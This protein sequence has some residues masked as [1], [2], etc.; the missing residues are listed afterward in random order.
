MKNRIAI[1]LFIPLYFGCT[2]TIEPFPK[3]PVP[4]V[5]VA[6]MFINSSLE[7]KKIMKPFKTI[8]HMLQ[9]T[10]TDGEEAKILALIMDCKTDTTLNQLVNKLY[11]TGL[12]TN[13]T[14]RWDEERNS[15]RSPGLFDQL[16]SKVSSEELSQTP[17]NKTFGNGFF[18]AVFSDKTLNTQSARKMLSAISMHI[19]GK[20]YEGSQDS[21]SGMQSMMMGVISNKDNKYGVGALSPDT[22]RLAKEIFTNLY[23]NTSFRKRVQNTRQALDRDNLM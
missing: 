8:H 20:P 13:L 4:E 9:D 15:Y 1:V 3:Y 14:Q 16:M 18:Y 2:E 6:G 7:D 11:D 12:L 17:P 23:G 19:Q 5:D 22:R 10:L 21:G